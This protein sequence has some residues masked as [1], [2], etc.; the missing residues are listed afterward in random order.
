MRNLFIVSASIVL[1]GCGG[2]MPPLPGEV[3]PLVVA[4]CPASLGILE[5]GT[6]G[7]TT[8]KLVEIAGVYYKCRAAAFAG[9]GAK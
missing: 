9:G 4:N 7:E 6:F 3:S 8:N 5:S 1:T 2:S